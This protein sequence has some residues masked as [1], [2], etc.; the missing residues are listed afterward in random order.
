MQIYQELDKDSDGVLTTSF[1][2]RVEN[3]SG[4]HPIES[5]KLRLTSATKRAGS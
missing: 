1:L 2:H 5:W 4:N 3:G